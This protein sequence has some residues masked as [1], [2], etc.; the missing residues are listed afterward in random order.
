MI[1]SLN[2]ISGYPKLNWTQGIQ[3]PKA[4]QDTIT[5]VKQPWHAMK[6]N[7]S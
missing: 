6:S 5:V 3:S 1:S 2:L 7:Q 4:I